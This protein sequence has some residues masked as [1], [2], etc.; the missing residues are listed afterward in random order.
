MLC[1][2]AGQVVRMASGGLLTYGRVLPV[3]FFALAQAVRK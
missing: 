3:S 2:R 1:S